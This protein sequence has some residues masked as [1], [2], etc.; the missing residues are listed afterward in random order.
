MNQTDKI[1]SVVSKYF[2]VPEA[3][4]TDA[5]EFPVARMQSSVARSTLHAA[6]KNMAGAD[7]TTVWTARSFGELIHGKGTA[8]LSPSN[9]TPAGGPQTMA[10]PRGVMAPRIGIDIEGVDG[11]PGTG[12]PWKESFYLENFAA[13]EI[14]YAVRQYDARLTLC[15]IW[16][17]KE[18]VL[19][20]GGPFSGLRPIQIEVSHDPSGRPSVSI[21][22]LTESGGID[23]S[24]SHAAGVAVAVSV[25][26]PVAPERA[27]AL[28]SLGAIKG[29]APG[30]GLDL[31]GNEDHRGRVNLAIFL[32]I[33]AL[34][35]AGVSIL[36]RL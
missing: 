36:S 24:I 25:Y 33:A 28:E 7:L 8:P 2:G 16:C 31:A 29:S 21:A 5:F 4:L 30:A 12:D 15:G 17:A 27:L 32:G 13:A 34:I 35:L 14:A 9:V 10:G 6:L 1:R 11:L 20:L 26:S 19:K 22:G 3:E 23:V 18:S